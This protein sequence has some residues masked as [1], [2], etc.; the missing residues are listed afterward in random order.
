MKIPRS[1]GVLL[2]PTSLPS[3]YGIGT[4]GNEAFQFAEALAAAGQTIWQMLPLGPVGFG[5]SPYQSLSAFAGESL[6]IDLERIARAGLLSQK[7]LEAAPEFSAGTVD[8][9]RVRAWKLPLL[10]Q[11]ARNFFAS[12]SPADRQL[13]DEFCSSHSGW[14]ENYALFAALRESYSERSWTAWERG[15]THRDPVALAA[16]RN[17]LREEIDCHK[18]C[19]FEFYRQWDALRAFC[20]ERGLLIMGDLPIYVSHDSADVWIHPDRFYLDRRGNPASVSGVPPDYFSETGQLWGNPIYRWSVMRRS[21]FQWWIERFRGTFRLFDIVRVDHFRG[22]ESYWCV[23]AR[24]KTAINGKWVKAPGRRLFRE[25]RK[26]LGDLNIVAENLGI[27]TPE[28]E[29]LRRE[30]GFPGMAVLQFAFSGDPQSASFRPHSFERSLFAY[31]GTHD[32]DTLMGWW[33]GEGASTRSN[34]QIRDETARARRYLGV[35]NE[36]VNWAFIRL[37][38]RSV[39]DAA[40]VPMQDVLGLD[41][42]ARMNL[43]G[44]GSGNWR[45]RMLPGAFTPALQAQ[46]RDLTETYGRIPQPDAGQ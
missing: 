25:L 38:W 19:Q 11:A 27:I 18:Y 33:N 21:G 36:P 28:V 40:I 45:W 3:R 13:F 17:K 20:R 8:Y 1:S 22:F 10:S 15:L 32:N 6:L 26:S 37:L 46:L 2:H 9:E 7:D 23:R 4:F 35:T 44:N 12:T 16:W 41:G 5:N 31:T 42:T 34:D 14:L 39:A 24:E 29:A 30:F 43:P